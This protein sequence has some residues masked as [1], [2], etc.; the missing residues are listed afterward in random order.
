MKDGAV[1]VVFSSDDYFVP[2]LAALVQS[3]MD[4]AKKPLRYRFFVLHRGIAQEN[5]RL[6]G[7]QVA[8]GGVAAAG[9][10]GRRGA[11]GPSFSLD[12]VDVSAHIRGYDFPTHFLP[13]ESYFRL[14][15]PYLFEYEKVL[16]LDS[17]MICGADLSELYALDLGEHLLAACR[18]DF[19][20]GDRGR[21]HARSIGLASH[22]DYFNAG[23]L[24]FNRAAFSRGVSMTGL[25]DL[26]VSRDWQFCDQDVLNV[27][28]AGKTLILN[29]EWNAMVT[30]YNEDQFP[31]ELRQEYR[32]SRARPK[33]SHFAGPKPWDRRFGFGFNPAARAGQ[34]E[35]F[36]RYAE[37]TPF[38]GVVRERMEA[39]PRREGR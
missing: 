31:P 35:L 8:A 22:R 15:I 29:M 10:A 11:E 17:D 7:S 21:Y 38:I 5:Q 13:A 39:L 9:D 1:P 4:N 28:C 6:L 36:L 14:L 19:L 37:K 20:A 12:F 2:Y 16:Y 25:L 18:D 32:R 3:I 30:M 34:L 23:M 26:A 33:I 24:L 27:V